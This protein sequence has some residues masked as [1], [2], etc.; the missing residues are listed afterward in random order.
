MLESRQSKEIT[1][2]VEAE[3]E[4]TRQKRAP[5]DLRNLVGGRFG[6]SGRQAVGQKVGSD[7]VSTTE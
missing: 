4:S 6:E 7:G 3:R 5:G 1:I 2:I